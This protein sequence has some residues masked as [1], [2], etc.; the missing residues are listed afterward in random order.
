MV[1]WEKQDKKIQKRWFASLVIYLPYKSLGKKAYTLTPNY[2]LQ[3]E[4]NC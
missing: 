1:S 2:I 3:N 4:A